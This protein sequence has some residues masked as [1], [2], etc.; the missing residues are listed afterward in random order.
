MDKYLKNNIVLKWKSEINDKNRLLKANRAKYYFLYI[1]I[2]KFTERFD[3]AESSSA[4]IN[5]YFFNY[6]TLKL[7]N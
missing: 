7:T 4:V 5:T 1:I 6:V 3:F 2:L